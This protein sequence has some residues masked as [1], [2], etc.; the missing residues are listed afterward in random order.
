MQTVQ[1]RCPH[2]QNVL[3]IPC[4]VARQT[5]ALQ[6]LQEHVPGQIEERLRARCRPPPQPKSASPSMAQPAMAGAVAGG[7]PPFAPTSGD[8]FGFDDMPAP[9]SASIKRRAPAAACTSSC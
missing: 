5:D 4:A 8:P 7:G 2:C 1:A 9:E 6:A 3:R